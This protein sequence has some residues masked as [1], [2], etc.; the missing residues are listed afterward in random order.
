METFDLYN[1]I[2]TRTGGDIY[3]GV[4]GPVR[5]GK[6]T[7][8]KRFMDKLVLPNIE[9][10]NVLS[11]AVDELPQSAD[12]KTVMT[13][14]PKFVP[15]EAVNV[16]IGDNINASVRLV[17]C[18]GYLVDGAL[19]ATEG[20]KTRM[21]KTPWSDNEMS[22]EEAAEIGTTK[23]IV[24]HSTIGVLLTS[25]GSIVDIPRAT[26]IE[27]EEKAVNRLKGIG[28]PFVIILNSK[29]P[30]DLDTI[31]LRDAL[32]ER[33]KVPVMSLDV[34]NMEL[35]HI[36]EIFEKL[37]QEFPVKQVDVFLPEWMRAMSSDDEIIQHTIKKLEDSCDIYKM[38]EAMVMRGL[39]SDSEFYSECDVQVEMGSGR[40][41]IYLKAKP[42]IFFKELSKISGNE[43]CD[44][45]Q[46][47][48][49]VK[50]LSDDARKY[51]KLKDALTQVEESGY[52]VVVPDQEDMVLEEP[53]IM[54]QSGKFGVRLKASAP[55]LHIMRVDVK[56]EVN[57]IV[58]SEQQSEELVKYLLEEFETNKKGI[59]E[60]NMFGKSLASLVNEGLGNK[61]FAL[62][63]EAKKKLR[64]A[65][66]KIV[67][68]GKGGII[69]I[70]L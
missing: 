7:F 1:D 47:M 21:V 12:G 43:I 2:A 27:A 67:N 39:F 4:V 38:S 8:I 69:C 36:N 60:T 59:W 29:H 28:K 41:N 66:G 54:K 55:S 26:Y 16:K 30:N 56:T 49:F 20:D 62:P 15:S 61:I 65:L 23:V 24:E 42:D 13:T 46:L 3:L 50:T 9:D 18:V 70:L 32:S 19:G 10:K 37:L 68:E 11:R 57:P 44:E 51:A 17:D 34:L 25:D 63:D 53:E 6:S 64:K 40:V 45:Y 58:G 5:T 52:G 22:F 31:K 35:S 14:Q 48:R 33:Y